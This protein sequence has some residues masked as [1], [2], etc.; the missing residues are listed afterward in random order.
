MFRAFESCQC[1][2]WRFEDRSVSRF[3]DAWVF[4]R[5]MLPESDVPARAPLCL[6]C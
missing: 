4:K 5:Q 1:P 3:R 6:L 2:L